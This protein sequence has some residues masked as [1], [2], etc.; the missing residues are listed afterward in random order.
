MSFQVEELKDKESNKNY[1]ED[2]IISPARRSVKWVHKEVH[3]EDTA[4]KPIMETIL[5]QV[6]EWHGIIGESMYKCCLILSLNVMKNHHSNTKFLVVSE[7]IFYSVNLLL[8]HNKENSD[9][10]RSKIFDKEHSLP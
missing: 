2:C 1:S 9:E 8:E 7:F 6:E 3:I 4:N 5:K 10:N